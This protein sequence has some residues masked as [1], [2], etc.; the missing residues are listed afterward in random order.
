[1]GSDL[2]TSLLR[3]RLIVTRCGLA[4]ALALGVASAA[5]QAQA[6]PAAR[7]IAVDMS[8]A[9]QFSQ[10]SGTCAKAAAPG[11]AVILGGV[12]AGALKPVEAVEQ[13]DQH[14]KSIRDYVEESHGRLR[15]LE[16]VRTIANPPPS[17]SGTERDLPFQVVQR[18]QAEFSADA[19]VDGILQR[20]IELGLD[21]FGDNVLAANGSRRET[22]IVFRFEDFDAEI[23]ELEKQCI[24]AAWKDWCATPS[25]G[26][27]C[28]PEPPEALQ[29]QVFTVRSAEKLLRPDGGAQYW[30]FS[31]T[32]AQRSGEPLELM[33]KLSVHLSGTIML[34][35]RVDT[36]P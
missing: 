30:Q 5:A 6:I 31:Y 7:A 15:L 33:D 19:P 32:G 16:R 36:A 9:A 24:A 28:P 10:F 2:P 8:G 29:V 27:P 18:L 34:L 3:A 21:R 35:Y 22:V 20:L 4:L 12:A 1:M 23:R 14:L 11:I 17:R 26:A 13:L 25:A